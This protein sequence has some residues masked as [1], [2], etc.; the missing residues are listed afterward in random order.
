MISFDKIVNKMLKKGGKIIF[1]ED[2]FEIIDPELQ[3]R[4]K[5]IVS[6]IIYKLKSQKIIIPIKN[7]MYV[8][9]KPGDENLN[10]IDLIE[11]YYFEFCKKIIN[12][13]VGSE[14]FISGKKSLEIHHKNYTIPQKLIVVNRKINKRILIGNYQIIFK[15]I[16]GNKKNLYSQLSNFTKTTQIEGINFKISS[17]ELSLIESALI[18]DTFEGIPIDLLSKTL[19]KYS[20]FF[21]KDLFYKIGKFKYIMAFNRLKELSKNID[22]NLYEVFLDIIKQNGGLFIGEG[23]RG[24]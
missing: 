11:K 16:T 8:V 23:K 6:K 2:I 5:S 24:I 22:K 15:T 7:G 19:K 12:K 21:D 18:E 17:L 9:P 13:E 1:L 3:E 20:K 10:E 14:Y 4:N